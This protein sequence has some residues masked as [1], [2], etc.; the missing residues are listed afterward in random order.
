MARRLHAIC[1]SAAA[2][3]APP[4]PGARRTP[5]LAVGKTLAGEPVRTTEAAAVAFGEPG[6]AVGPCMATGTEFAE[7]EVAAPYTSLAGR[8]PAHSP[9]AW[10]CHCQ[11]RKRRHST[12]R[13]GRKAG[14]HHRS[15]ACTRQ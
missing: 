5:A 9:E 1:R 12:R 13:R 10:L 11:P 15:A 2:L 7:R 6:S 4:A 14:R 3:H 8:Q